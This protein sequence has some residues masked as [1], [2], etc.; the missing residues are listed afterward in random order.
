MRP[1]V[2]HTHMPTSSRQPCV[3]RQIVDTHRPT[4]ADRF[5]RCQMH[6]HKTYCQLLVENIHVAITF[7]LA[8]E[9]SACVGRAGQVIVGVCGR[10]G[11]VIVISALLL[12]S[13]RRARM[14]VH[15]TFTNCSFV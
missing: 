4:S 2:R 11:Q 3:C 13:D 12:A 10:A 7:E 14:F 1:E 5:F 6:I 8:T 9:E 15:G